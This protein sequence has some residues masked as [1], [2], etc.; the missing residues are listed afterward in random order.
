MLLQCA[1]DNAILITYIYYVFSVS[2]HEAETISLGAL[3]TFFPHII[4]IVW[5][6][7][8][9]YLLKG[10]NRKCERH[11]IGKSPKFLSSTRWQALIK[12]S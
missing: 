11:E 4:L 8:H 5:S 7:L 3:F 1:Y 10:Y 9:K 6:V 2:T 12:L